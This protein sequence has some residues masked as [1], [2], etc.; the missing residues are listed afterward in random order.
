[1]GPFGW[2]QVE[3]IPDTRALIAEDISHTFNTSR[4]HPITVTNPCIT[5]SACCLG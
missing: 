3:C 5:D 4:T 2:I 1:M